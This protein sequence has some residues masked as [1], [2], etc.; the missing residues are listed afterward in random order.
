[1]KLINSLTVVFFMFFEETNVVNGMSDNLY[2]W[3]LT[4]SLS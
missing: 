4:Q 1:M 3:S 2:S